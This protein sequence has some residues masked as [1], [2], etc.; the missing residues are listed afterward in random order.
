MGDGSGQ[1]VG[2]GVD[3]FRPRPQVVDLALQTGQTLPTVGDGLDGGQ[4]CRFRGLGDRFA[5]A[6]HLACRLELFGG[7]LD[8]LGQFG[9]EFGGF[10]GLFLEFLGIGS[11][12]LGGGLAEVAAAFG[13]DPAGRVDAFGQRRQPEPGAARRRGGRGDLGEMLFVF[14]DLRVGLVELLGHLVLAAPDLVL[15]GGVFGHLGSAD[16]QVVGGEAQPG[17]AEIGLHGL[18]PAGDLGLSAERLELTP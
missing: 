3:R 8:A 11:G 6:E 13:G 17:V 2:L 16:H 1:A 7:D 5:L 9:L 4:V 15:D 10:E 12:G 14:G 18:R